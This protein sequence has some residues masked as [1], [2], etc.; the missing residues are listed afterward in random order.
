MATTQ[1]HIFF[2]ILQHLIKD[3]I[4]TSASFGESGSITSLNVAVSIDPIVK[5]IDIKEETILTFLSLLEKNTSDFPKMLDI[6]GI[7]PE[8]VIVTMK[9]RSLEELAKTETIGQ[10]ILTCGKTLDVRASKWSRNKNDSG[11][12]AYSFGSVQFSVVQCSRLL[13]PDAEPRHVYAALRRL[14]TN[15]ELE[16]R[17]DNDSGRSIF[18]KINE[19]G[20]NYFHTPDDCESAE[21]RLSHLVHSM[22]EYLSQQAINQCKKV[23][24]MHKIFQHITV[25]AGEERNDKSKSQ[26]L[27]VFQR[28]IDDYFNNPCIDNTLDAGQ[29]IQK[30]SGKDK[31]IMNC[32]RRDVLNLL[33]DTSLKVTQSFSPHQ[34][35]FGDIEQSDYTVMLITKILHGIPSPNTP[36]LNWYNHPLWGKYKCYDFMNICSNVQTIICGE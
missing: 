12:D 18:L 30:V 3:A 33:Q 17:F 24:K 34:V 22:S 15:G 10:C 6:E 32:L 35:R 16:L 23:L 5:S 14:Q 4:D 7:I 27:K 31:A 36:S 26:N 2:A 9:L 21:N 20:L 25:E 19:H 29:L 8:N 13:G 28:I 1:V 11:F